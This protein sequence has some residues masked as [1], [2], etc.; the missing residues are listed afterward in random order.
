MVQ[1]VPSLSQHRQNGRSHSSNLKYT[2]LAL[3]R[4]RGHGS[5]R[6]KAENPGPQDPVHVVNKAGGADVADPLLNSQ[7]VLV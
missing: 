2:H 6:S 4:D 5:A 3:R 1:T 7:L